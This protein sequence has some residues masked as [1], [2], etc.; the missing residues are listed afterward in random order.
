MGR[1]D[2]DCGRV[3]VLNRSYALI[4]IYRYLWNIDYNGVRSTYKSFDN[5][6]KW[7]HSIH[8][9]TI[10][11][12][13]QDSTEAVQ[14][15]PFGKVKVP[16]KNFYYTYP[17][18]QQDNENEFKALTLKSLTKLY[19]TREHNLLLRMTKSVKER[20]DL[21]DDD[22]LH[23]NIIMAL[24]GR[25]F[26]GDC[27]HTLFEQVSWDF[28]AQANKYRLYIQKTNKFYD[29]TFTK[30]TT[31]PKSDE[32]LYILYRIF[33]RSQKSF[34]GIIFSL[35]R[36]LDFRFNRVKHRIVQPDYLDYRREREFKN[37]IVASERQ[38]QGLYELFCF[39]RDNIPP[40]DPELKYNFFS[41]PSVDTDEALRLTIL[42]QF[43]KNR[44]FFNKFDIEYKTGKVYSSLSII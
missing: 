11:L 33:R 39:F 36:L 25:E 37:V 34:H 35:E 16:C 17:H 2:G 19:Y 1:L 7:L 9:Q 20:L 43:F 26:N 22:N 40:I 6:Q 5:M 8:K 18:E 31:P 21:N 28:F 23:S 12:Y 38:L 41:H 24:N 4:G 10:K 29:E 27:G 3:A 42:E 30:I 14:Y 44:E 32:K 13:E 15:E